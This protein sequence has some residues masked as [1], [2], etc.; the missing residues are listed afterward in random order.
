MK[1]R[2]F[3]R[4]DLIILFSALGLSVIGILF[5]Y[6]SGISS[7]GVLQNNEYIKQIVWTCV[8]AAIMI[9]VSFFDYERLRALSL[10]IY[11]AM[12]VA[13]ILVLILGDVVNG[14]RSWLTIKGIG[15]QPSE[16]MKLA[17]VIRLAYFFEESRNKY[18]NFIRFILSLIQV[19][20]PMFLVMIQPDMGT[21]MVYIPIY[22]I[23]AFAAG[24]KIRYIFFLLASGVLAI[25]GVMVPA[26]DSYIVTEKS[27]QL[28][29]V[30]SDHNL[31]LIVIIS[32][33]M[34]YLLSGAGLLFFKKRYFYW[35]G[36]SVLILMIAF[37]MTLGASSFIKD[38]QLKRLI[39]F[40]DPQVD[41]KGDGW[42]VIQSITAVGSGG[43]VGKGYLQGTQSHYRYLPQQST[44]FIFSILS[45]EWGFVGCMAVFVLFAIILLRSL[46]ILLSSRDPFGLYIGSGIVAMIFFHFLVNIGMAMGIMP[47][48]GIPLLL[49]SYGGSSML[50]TMAGL[51]LISSIYL[52]KYK[53]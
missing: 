29:K 1:S 12:I 50:T 5:I 40:I 51:G 3:L 14:A 9:G 33:V 11:I 37:T 22:L 47:I 4:F 28:A 15:F 44:D 36:Y 21:A 24:I 27:I 39:I 23:M 10:Y 18:S 31:I 34:I 30:F 6:S 43:T 53:Y 35:I 52:H 38:Y 42:H 16:F 13:L 7:D 20:I 2:S 17:L 41:P 45:E 32:T 26:W 25:V 49:V 48:T 19:A 46:F 8:G